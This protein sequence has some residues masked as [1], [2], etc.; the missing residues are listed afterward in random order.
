MPK[1]T[2]VGMSYQDAI[3]NFTENVRLVGPDP[4]SDP[5]K[6]NLNHGL[7]ELTQALQRDLEQ[8]NYKLDL[9]LHALNQR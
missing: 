8:L 4:M 6:W 2:I 3:N 5:Q 9:I 7:Y 1:S